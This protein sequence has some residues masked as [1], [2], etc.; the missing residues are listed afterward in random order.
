MG[1]MNLSFDQVTLIPTYVF[2]SQISDP[3]IYSSFNAR[4]DPVLLCLK[5][6]GPC[7]NLFKQIVS[8][9]R[10]LFSKEQQVKWKESFHQQPASSTIPVLWMQSLWQILDYC[11]EVQRVESVDRNAQK[12]QKIHKIQTLQY[13]AR[14]QMFG[15][16]SHVVDVHVDLVSL[17]LRLWNL[18]FESPTHSEDFRLCG[19]YPDETNIHWSTLFSNFSSFSKSEIRSYIETSSSRYNSHKWETWIR[20]VQP[21]I[22]SMKVQYQSD[23]Q[24]RISC[25][26]RNKLKVGYMFTCP[27]FIQDWIYVMVKCNWM[28]STYLLQ[29]WSDIVRSGQIQ[30]I[31]TWLKFMSRNWKDEWSRVKS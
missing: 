6:I 13:V 23:G 9:F 20:Y 7:L 26:V 17:L 10:S 22:S 2:Y 12:F 25:N 18:S 31:E 27:T 4:L 19:T 15:L 3:Y 29:N 30:W 8:Y 14:S 16:H 11:D 5:P 24:L 28:H 21:D 1:S